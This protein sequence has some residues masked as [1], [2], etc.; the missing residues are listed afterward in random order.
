VETIPPFLMAGTR[1]AIS[2][3]I[4]YA[5]SRKRGSPSPPRRQWRNALIAGSLLL[6]GGNGAVVWAEQ[7]VPSGLTA[8]LVSVVPFWLVVFDWLRPGGRPPRP[9]VAAGLILGLVG[10]FVL[11]NPTAVTG[12]S[13]VNL[14]GAGVLMLGSVSWALGSFYSRDADLPASGFMRTGLEMLCGG[15]VL[16]AIGVFS[17]EL[18]RLDVHRVTPASAIGLVYLITFGALLGFTS[19][20]WL[21]DKVSPARAGTYAYVNPIVAVLLGWAVA[22]ES[23]SSRTIVAAA[24]VIGAVAL[25]T[26]SRGGEATSS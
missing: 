5:W 20:I 6:V 22:G 23:L 17:G 24:I 7:Y 10:I 2:G 4:L 9:A 12:H 18:S 25:I 16:L 19:Y 13:S 8:L 15:A 14:P 3:I 1:F 21:L 11:V 26:T